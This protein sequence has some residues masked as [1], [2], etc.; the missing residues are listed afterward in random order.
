VKIPGGYETLTFMFKYIIFC[1]LLLNGTLTTFKLS[2][3]SSNQNKFCVVS[4]SP[5]FVAKGNASLLLYPWGTVGHLKAKITKCN[6]ADLILL[7][8]KNVKVHRRM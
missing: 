6:V 7:K 5:G 8:H 2:E 3:N 1:T 4:G